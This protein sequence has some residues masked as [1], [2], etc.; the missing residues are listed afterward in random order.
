MCS[1]TPSLGAGLGK[2]VDGLNCTL[3]LEAGLTAVN[4]T[5][6]LKAG[7]TAVSSTVVT[8]R[9]DLVHF[10][11][12]SVEV[13]QQRKFKHVLHCTTL[14]TVYFGLTLS[15]TLLRFSVSVLSM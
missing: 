11:V 13:K 14:C 5:L 1:G 10:V 9:C 4:C 12:S 2:T 7:L 6:Q 15:R 3:Q 8:A